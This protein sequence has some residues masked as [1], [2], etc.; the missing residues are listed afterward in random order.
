MHLRQRQGLHVEPAVCNNVRKHEHGAAAQQGDGKEDELQ[1]AQQAAV[2]QRIGRA[3][4]KTRRL[5]RHGGCKAH[6]QQVEPGLQ[7]GE[8]THQ[9]ISLRAHVFQTQGKDENAYQRDVNLGGVA[10]E[11]VFLQGRHYEEDSSST[12]LTN[13]FFPASLRK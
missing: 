2:A 8:E 10:S 3:A 11:D 4:M 6:V 7:H 5:T 9:P 13:I 12:T 1:C